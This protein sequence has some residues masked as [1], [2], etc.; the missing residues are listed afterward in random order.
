[1]QVALRKDADEADK[2]R[3]SVLASA[4]ESEEF[5]DGLK[6]KLYEA[7][8]LAKEAEGERSARASA[9][10][11]PPFTAPGPPF[12]AP[13]PP[14]TAPTPPFAAPTPPF[15]AS[16]RADKSVA[17]A[18]QVGVLQGRAKARAK[19]IVAR[20][21][22]AAERA[23]ATADFK[24]KLAQLERKVGAAQERQ[25]AKRDAAARLKAL[26]CVALR[27]RSAAW[28]AADC[29][30]INCL[31]RRDALA[32]AIA[33]ADAARARLDEMAKASVSSRERAK[34]LNEKAAADLARVPEV[35]AFDDGRGG[36][37]T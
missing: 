20:K 2:A 12:T 29:P 34:D 28:C 13:D 26:K 33:D 32:K 37:R 31:P 11:D 8:R 25:Q 24:R 3:D 4:M 15:T 7:S 21:A 18:E 6:K 30:P 5:V 9:P 27:C 1:M 16:L 19:A 14:F 10:P 22:E 36:P 17:L 35:R 23:T